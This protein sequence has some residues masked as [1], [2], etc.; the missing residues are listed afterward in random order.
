MQIENR[1]YYFGRDLRSIHI[2]TKSSID[3]FE[4]T[5]DT[6]VLYEILIAPG[7]E[8][9]ISCREYCHLILFLA[10]KSVMLSI[11]INPHLYM[12]N[13]GVLYLVALTLGISLSP[14]VPALRLVLLGKR[15]LKSMTVQLGSTEA[16]EIT[17]GRSRVSIRRLSNLGDIK[18]V[19]TST[20]TGSVHTTV[21]A[22]REAIAVQRML[23]RDA[24]G[25]TRY[26][27][28]IKAQFGVVSPDS[29]LQRPEY[30][31]PR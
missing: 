18:T 12:G 11:V 10:I 9:A 29:R 6:L 31:S 16:G 13:F 1:Y 25:G 15:L 7:M 2:L 28:I 17:L 19:I 30:L 5:Q 8:Q 4:E 22:L 24:R 20:L 27:E 21:N 23:E 14:S 3:Q 26:I